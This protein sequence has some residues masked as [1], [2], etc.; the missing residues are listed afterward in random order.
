MKTKKSTKKSS[1]KAVKNTVVNESVQ[2][3]EQPVEET[4]VEQPTVSEKENVEQACAETVEQPTE[5]PQEPAEEVLDEG[6]Y[7]LFDNGKKILFSEIMEKNLRPRAVATGI[8]IVDAGGTFILSLKEAAGRYGAHL[9]EKDG[10]SAAGYI[11][12]YKEACCDFDAEQNT[13][14]LKALTLGEGIVLEEGWNIPTLGQL[15]IIFNHKDELNTALAFVKGH[16][17]TPERYWSSTQF[18]EKNAWSYDFGLNA[19]ENFEKNS[20][21]YK[22][23]PVLRFDVENQ[24]R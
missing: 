24:G 9:A 21:N 19:A 23:R 18:S 3:S 2:V 17:L 14:N 11:T 6:I 20:H 22:V 4:A 15:Q 5:T 1:K 16:K 7:L 13:E 12:D 8:L 10:D